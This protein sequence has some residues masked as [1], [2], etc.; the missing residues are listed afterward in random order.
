MAVELDVPHPVL[1]APG[2]GEVVSNRPG[3]VVHLLLAN[4][5][6]DVTWSQFGPHE[7]GTDP[8]VHREHTDAFYVLDGALDLV[9]GPGTPWIS[10]P[11]GT[12]VAIPPNV[13]H[14]F[15]AGEEQV[16]FLNLHAPSGGFAGYLRGASATFDSFDPPVDGGAPASTAIVS[17]P[18]EGEKLPRG[19]R[20]HT[21]KAQLPHVAIIELT[22]EPGWEGVD[23]H[24]HDDH[25]DAF[26]VLDG[27]VRFLAGEGSPG[28][29]FA[30]PP[31][32]VHGF[33]IAGGTPISV[34][35]VHAP[36]T[37]FTDRLR[38]SA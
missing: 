8:H 6:L 4:D 37:G 19:N 38:H 16:T 2:D 23:P 12:L 13:V 15:R 31:G 27:S 17:P 30:A 18:D 5:L 14:A 20:F 36:D 35:N 24:V 26:F 9:L 1:L 7:S 32:A 21:V 29:F 3:H 11:A 25:V 22:F 34:L 28:S 33:A 10:H